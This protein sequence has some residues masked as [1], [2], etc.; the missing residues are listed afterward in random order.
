MYLKKEEE[1]PKETNPEKHAETVKEQLLTL[2]WEWC[3]YPHWQWSCQIS[4][5][6]VC[7]G[8][9]PGHAPLKQF[10]PHVTI[11]ILQE[12]LQVVHYGHSQTKTKAYIISSTV[13]ENPGTPCSQ[14]QD[15]KSWSAITKHCSWSMTTDYGI[16]VDN[17]QQ[18]GTVDTV[19]RCCLPHFHSSWPCFVCQA[20]QLLGA[21]DAA[22]VLHGM[23]YQTGREAVS[24][25][26]WHARPALTNATIE[27]P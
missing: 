12:K 19:S 21:K 17:T 5:L 15:T 26:S 13:G 23:W 22:S 4:F 14:E 1:K 6:R 9:P 25:L 2:Y 20:A 11:S 7:R 10:A 8:C 16:M 24:M 27:S 3:C 18:P